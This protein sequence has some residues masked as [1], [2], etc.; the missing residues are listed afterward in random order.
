MLHL[1]NIKYNHLGNRQPE[2]NKRG[3][4][5]KKRVKKSLDKAFQFSSLVKA[6]KLVPTNVLKIHASIEGETSTYMNVWRKINTMSL[7]QKL[8]LKKS[9]ELIIPFLRKLQQM[10]NAS[11][12]EYKVDEEKR[13]LHFFLFW[14]DQ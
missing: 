11:T 4:H 10:N 2:T 14:V 1:T 6:S 5:Y 13:I 3:H 8:A 9:Y 12:I 7:S